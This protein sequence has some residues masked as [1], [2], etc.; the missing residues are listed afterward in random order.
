MKKS[1]KAKLVLGIIFIILLILVGIGYYFYNFHVFK[2]LRVCVTDEVTDS[3]IP[4]SS[5]KFCIEQVKQNST[6]FEKLEE[7]PDFIKNK[8]EEV[9]ESAIYCEETCKLK[10]IRGLE[11]LGEIESCEENG[12]EFLFE[13][14]GKQG[15]EI[16][17]YLKQIE[18]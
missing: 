4:C 3:M 9:L 16:L 11:N 7:L 6:D 2:T 5:N 12:Q 1:G 14:R 17:K 8:I 13:I 15:L 18:N 10:K